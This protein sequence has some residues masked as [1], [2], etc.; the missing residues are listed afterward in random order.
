MTQNAFQNSG[1]VFL[2]SF[3]VAVEIPSQ[4][5]PSTW[6]TS[7]ILSSGNHV[8]QFHKMQ[9]DQL[10]LHCSQ[11]GYTGAS[12][13]SPP[14]CIDMHRSSLK[15]WISPCHVILCILCYP[16]STLCLVPS[17][18]QMAPV[19]ASKRSTGSWCQDLGVGSKNVFGKRGPGEA[20]SFPWRLQKR[21]LKIKICRAMQEIVSTGESFLSQV[22]GSFWQ[23]KGWGKGA[24]GKLV[25]LAS[26]ATRH[27]NL[28][29]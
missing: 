29:S 1:I 12:H 26:Y 24:F 8:W 14:H 5:F 16:N 15:A 20:G 3:C 19:L 4:T 7:H 25:P 21:Q 9:G 23:Q 18:S 17:C 10:I 28:S 11:D 2:Y 6:C 13:V 22:P 27:L